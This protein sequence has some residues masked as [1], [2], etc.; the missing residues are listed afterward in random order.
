MTG[1]ERET[2]RVNRYPISL[3]NPTREFLFD[4]FTV[5]E[6]RKHCRELGLT[7]VWVNKDELVN[8]ILRST[9]STALERTHESQDQSQTDLLQNICQELENLKINM[10]RKDSQIEELNEML[11]K[12]HVTI[13]RLNDRITTL[14][15]QIGQQNS[16][17]ET[18]REEK[19]LLLGDDNLNEV[20]ISDLNENCSIKSIKDVNFDLMKCWVNEKLDVIPTKCIIYCGLNDLIENENVNS[21]LDDLGSLISELK[22][23]NENVELFVSELAPSINESVDNKIS[24]FNNKLNEWSSV[25]GIKV[26]KMNLS[27]KLGTGE[28][29]E[30]CFK[31]ENEKSGMIL[32][33]FG[34]LRLLSVMHKQSSCMKAKDYIETSDSSTHLN[35]FLAKDRNVVNRKRAPKH[36][37]EEQNFERRYERQN[38]YRWKPNY[39]QQYQ[40]PV[41]YNFS[42]TFDFK[43]TNR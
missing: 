31:S 36:Q 33:R 40:Q 25:N 10:S 19:T 16:E 5:S 12:A 1:N 6:L 34:A 32:N 24:H 41:N 13:N 35:E 38:Y 37:F 21:V 42:R 15:D 17:T 20:R 26:I 18:P 28:I 29:Y 30:M 11:K 22:N 43:L 14:E 7:K 3:E 8:M 2:E 23:K 27:F 9:R 39:N 4:N